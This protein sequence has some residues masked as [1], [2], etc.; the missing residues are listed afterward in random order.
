MSRLIRAAAAALLGLSVA[1]PPAALPSPA[2][3]KPL[4]GPPTPAACRALG[5]TIPERPES[6]AVSGMARSPSFG[7]PPPPS[8]T[9][10]ARA[11]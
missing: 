4:D 10:T 9:C 6:I 2:T 3:A 5:F 8:A 1:A 7:P 11:G